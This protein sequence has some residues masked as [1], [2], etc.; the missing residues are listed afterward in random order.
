MAKPLKILIV[1]DE[2][3]IAANL[4]LQLKTLG[5]EVCGTMP[6]GEEALVLAREQKPDLV[7]VD[8][9][10]K[11]ALD[12]IQTVQRMQREQDL[13]V[14]YLTANDDDAHFERAK[15]TNPFAFLSKPFKKQE[16][17]RTIELAANR[18]GM[19]EENEAVGQV[20]DLLDDRIF[21]RH[22][23]SMVKLMIADILYVE[24]DR[25][26]CRIHTRGDEYLLVAMLKEMEE[27]LPTGRF[28]RI[29]RSF[30]VNL[31][32]V[33]EVGTT[34]VVVVDKVIPMSKAMRDE[35]LSRLYA[36]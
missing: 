12:G 20:L 34:H 10:L 16:L 5:Y 26:Y 1:E 29:H 27:K 2:M 33:E 8:I 28:L 15:T 14:V 9:Q 32:L 19:S 3:L 18:I 30:V 7:L 31:T 17:Q 24:A 11:G 13:T 6:R 23:D 35:L 25:N 4:A 36:I 22:N 21:V